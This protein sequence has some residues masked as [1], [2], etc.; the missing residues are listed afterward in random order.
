MRIYEIAICNDH[1]HFVG[2]FPT[3]ESYTQFIKAL[4]GAIARK[5]KIKFKFRPWSRILNWG[6]SFQIA[7]KYVLQNHLE[8]VRAIPYQ[9]RAKDLAQARKLL[10]EAQRL[11]SAE[12]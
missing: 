2:L 3:K 1:I 11:R 9:P 10:R 5:F 8:S 4:T 7:I 6:R 12:L